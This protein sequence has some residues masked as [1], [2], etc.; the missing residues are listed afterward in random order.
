[1]SSAHAPI[2]GECFEAWP[3]LSHRQKGKRSWKERQAREACHRCG[4][5]VGGMK[6]N[7]PGGGILGE[8]IRYH[9]RQGACR[10]AGLKHLENALKEATDP[11]LRLELERE[12][13]RFDQDT[14][15]RYAERESRRLVKAGGAVVSREEADD[16]LVTLVRLSDGEVVVE[17]RKDADPDDDLILFAACRQRG[18]ELAKQTTLP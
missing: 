11:L 8:S 2:C 15:R 3:C 17:W 9:G 14:L 10:T 12:K 7:I 5:Q 6:I 18:F 16:R 4:K 1:M 13:E